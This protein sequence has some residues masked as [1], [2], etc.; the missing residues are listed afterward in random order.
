MTFKLDSYQPVEFWIALEFS[1]RK[2][3]PLKRNVSF[4][5]PVLRFV[6]DRFFTEWVM[7]MWGK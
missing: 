5:G 7:D 3:D 2:S 6:S 1:V 4:G